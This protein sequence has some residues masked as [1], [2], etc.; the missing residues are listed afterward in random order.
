M[1]QAYCPFP[2]IKKRTCV[3]GLRRIGTYAT[4]RHAQRAD[5]GDGWILSGPPEDKIDINPA[6]CWAS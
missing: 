2:C 6:M 5:S 1:L 4:G 3:G